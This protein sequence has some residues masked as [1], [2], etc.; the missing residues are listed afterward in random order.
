MTDR[1]AAELQTVLER[2][3][4]DDPSLPGI[5]ATVRAP[6]LGLDWS[7]ACGATRRGGI[8][9]LT[10]LHAFRVASVT[11][12]FTSAV[13][14]RLH[15]QGRLNVFAPMAGHV[16]AELADALEIAGYA[17]GRITLYHLL[18]H[19]SGLRDHAGR[20][21]NYGEVLMRNPAHVWTH[22][23]QVAACLALGGP[24]SDPGMRFAYSDTGYLI[25]GDILEDIAGR[26]LHQLMRDLL[27]FD[28][29]GLRQ[30]HFERHEPAPAGQVRT[31]QFLGDVDVA[32]IDC[33]CDLSGGGGLV[34]TTGELATWYRAAAL[35]E[36][37]DQPQTHS[38]A[39]ST[40][41]LR[42]EPPDVL[43][44]PLM[45]GRV[46]GLEPCWMHGGAWGLAAGYCPGSDIAW[47]LS[48]NQLHA[49]TWTVGMP[50]DPA[51]PSLADRLLTPVQRA[52]HA[53]H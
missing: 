42:F 14:L 52:V 50:G 29:L 39:L 4:S 9:A 34:S 21:T 35:G 8:E 25:L 32:T 19:G 43:H 46:V 15:E 1:L 38:L 40:P 18:T 31:G 10:P 37:F 11:K 44:A 30:T 22:A 2:A 26:P 53:C 48:F 12:P 28:Q 17:P 41:S 5:V 49:G 36:L 13:A 20:N 24:L 33:S 6:R 27:R 45:R 23:E 7:S 3:L 16:P 47:A 51:Q